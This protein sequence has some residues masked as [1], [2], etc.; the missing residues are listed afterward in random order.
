MEKGSGTVKIFAT[1]MTQEA[2]KEGKGGEWKRAKIDGGPGR[3]SECPGTNRVD[4]A[5]RPDRHPARMLNLPAAGRANDILR[6]V[7][8]SA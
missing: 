5:A 7:P 3:R 1:T 2:H 6:G 8:E 4:I